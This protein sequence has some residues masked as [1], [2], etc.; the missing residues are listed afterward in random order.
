MAPQRKQRS[1]L[2]HKTARG[3]EAGP[4]VLVR[5]LHRRDLN[6]VWEFLKRSFRDVNLET[7]EYQ[8]PRSKKRFFETYEEEGVEQLLFVADGEIVAY[9]ECTFEIIG[10]DTW[11]NPRYFEKRDMRPLY[12]EELAVHPD[13]HGRGVGSF[14]LE[15]IT[16]LAKVRGL[17]HLV[18]EVAENNTH[19]MSWYRKR[20]FRKLD[21]S[22]FMAYAVD[23]AP[24]LLPPRVLGSDEE[25]VVTDEQAMAAQP[26]DGE[27]SSA[28]PPAAPARPKARTRARRKTRGKAKASARNGKAAGARARKAASRGKAAAGEAAAG[29]LA[30]GK[31]ATADKAASGKA[32]TADKAAGK[33]AVVGKPAVG[34]AAAAAK[35]VAGK[36]AAVGKA[37]AGSAAA[38]AKPVVG[39][40]AA[41]SKPG[42][43]GLATPGHAVPAPPGKAA[44][45]GKS[46]TA[47]VIGKT[48]AGAAVKA[49]PAAR[50]ATD[51]APATSR[52]VEAAEPGADSKNGQRRA[53]T[54]P[55]AAEPTPGRRG[56]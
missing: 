43:P 38:A 12:V 30:A 45:V 4:V 39:K 41:A 29:K 28:T 33:A 3:K 16:H 49:T 35:P 11:I 24:E 9:S 6:K 18:L 50:P 14:V 54:A 20:S 2:R 56:T 55:P 25:A 31:A 32:A 27:A 47:A 53:P 26:V 8:R 13:W 48:A 22:V 5:R 17:T 36:P 21:A 51:A 52:A 10:S 37:A 19:A 15:Q 42:A 7:V 34:S 23:V 44:V 46:A 1:P 40:P